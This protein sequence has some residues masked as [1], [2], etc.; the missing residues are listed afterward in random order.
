[1]RDRFGREIT[2]LRLS[3]TDR[4]SLRC[5]YCVPSAGQHWLP[6]ELLLTDDELVTVVEAAAS[7]GVKKLRLTGGEPL[8]RPGLPALC[9]RLQRIPG[10]E[11][12]CITTNG[13]LLPDQAAALRRAG[14]TRV[15]LSLDT[16]SADKYRALTGGSLE[17]AMRGLEAALSTGFR[18]KVNAVLIRNFSEEEIVSLADLTRQYPLDVRFIEQMPMTDANQAVL[19]TSAVLECLPEAQLLPED[20][21][22]ARC[23]RLPGA[24]GDIGLISPISGSFCTTCN[25]IRVT[26][27]GFCKPCLHGAAEF[28]LRGLDRN[29]MARQMLRA[30]QAKPACHRGWQTGEHSDAGRPMYRIGG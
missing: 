19:P 3:V 26:A 12:V 21:G 30:I 8:Q 16:L 10:I 1:M 13:L 4:C 23:Y 27:D 20:G 28:S 6:S 2:Y 25:R 22:V 29:G 14:V 17:A 9:A 7:L 24:V 15:N 11:T 5:R 18:V